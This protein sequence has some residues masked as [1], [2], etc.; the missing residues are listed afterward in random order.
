MFPPSLVAGCD[1]NAGAASKGPVCALCPEIP[2]SDLVRCRQE[3][4]SCRNFA[5]ENN[6]S[7]NNSS[8]SSRTTT[9]TTTTTTTVT[10]RHESGTVAQKRPKQRNAQLARH[11]LTQPSNAPGD[12]TWREVWS[13]HARQQLELLVALWLLLVVARVLIIAAVAVA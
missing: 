1:A 12:N 7:S 3:V 11:K 6:R 5:A 4:A 9:T 13:K 2:Q 8:S 10:T